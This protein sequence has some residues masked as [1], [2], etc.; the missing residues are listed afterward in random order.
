MINLPNGCYISEMRITPKNL[1]MKKD[2]TIY[3]S[4]YDPEYPKPKLRQICGMNQFKTLNERKRQTKKLMEW[5]LNSLMEGLNPFKNEI[6][7]STSEVAPNT[8][9]IQALNKALEKVKVEPN[10][11]IDIRSVVKGTSIAARQLNIDT[12]PISE[13]TRKFFKMI[14]EKCTE[15]NPRFSANRKNVY[16][17]WLKRVFDEL[18]EMEAVETNPLIFIRKEKVEKN[19]R[20]LPNDEERTAISEYLHKNHYPFWRALQIF[21]ASGSREVELIGVRKF[22]VDLENQKCRYT[23]KKGKETTKVWR[24]IIDATLYLWKEIYNKAGEDDYLFSESLEPGK[25]RI[26]TEQFSRRWRRHVQLKLGINVKL[27]TLKH[28]NTTEL[29]DK[30]DKEYNPVNDVMGLTAHTSGKM[31]AKVYDINNDSRKNDKIKR[32]GGLF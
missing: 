18:I 7:K 4:F 20:L 12:K 6:I 14:F 24:P 21:F 26:R 9:F 31:I 29:M 1:D 22:D 23:I 2:W 30:L 8:P 25:N 17:K 16:R 13:V 11:L 27:Y 19:I 32:V 3:Y 15:T 28:L 5:E 10:T